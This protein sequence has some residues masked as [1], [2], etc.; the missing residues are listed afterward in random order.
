[1]K[2]LQKKNY[3]T[4][5][6]FD[7]SF[8]GWIKERLSN[9]E[10]L[11]IKGEMMHNLALTSDIEVE[12]AFYSDFDY[13]DEK[14][15]DLLTKYFKGGKLIDL[16]CLNSPL[17][18]ETKKKF[19]DSEIWALDFADEVI[20]Y[21]K[22]KYPQIKWIC[23][24]AMKIPAENEYFDYVIAGELLEHIENPKDFIKE[25]LRV[26]KKD[27]IFALSLPYKEQG[28]AV[29]KQEHIWSFNAED[30]NNLFKPYGGELELSYRGE[31]SWPILLAWYFKS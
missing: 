18:Y 5:K 14:R 30:I 25:V 17:A 3:N 11:R 7:K 27:G 26:L 24:D 21:Y 6:R 8:L 10:T 31:F 15:L 20:K 22:P 12:K 28:G 29:N 23:A 9:R 13:S 2:R 1:M 16:G 19:P 4:P